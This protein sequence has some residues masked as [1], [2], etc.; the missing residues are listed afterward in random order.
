MS[1]VKKWQP[2]PQ[3]QL[4][5]WAWN[6]NK[7]SRLDPVRLHCRHCNCTVF[8]VIKEKRPF[9][10]KTKQANRMRHAMVCVSC[11]EAATY[12]KA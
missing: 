11:H 2:I 4:S 7:P 6:P 8:Q 12:L 9:K 3:T 5:T 1:K 10:R